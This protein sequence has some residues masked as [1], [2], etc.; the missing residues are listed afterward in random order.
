MQE[1]PAGQTNYQMDPYAGKPV[2]EQKPNYGQPQAYGNGAAYPNQV[3][4][5]VAAAVQQAEAADESTVLDR[6]PGLMGD[7]DRQGFVIKT[8][9]LICTM[10]AFTTAWCIYTGNNKSVQLW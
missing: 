6:V 9:S 1:M 4:A 10:L 7:R 5:D 3:P 8:Y 2:V